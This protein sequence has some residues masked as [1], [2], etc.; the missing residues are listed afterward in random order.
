MSILTKTSICGESGVLSVI[1]K[2]ELVYDGGSV[3]MET[4][5]I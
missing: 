4:S 5:G 3:D 2:T 1:A